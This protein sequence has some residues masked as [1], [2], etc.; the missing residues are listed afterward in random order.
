MANKRVLALRKQL[1]REQLHVQWLEQRLPHSRQLNSAR[2]RIA[3][4]CVV[5]CVVETAALPTHD[6]A[7]K[8]ERRQ[9]A[10]LSLTKVGFP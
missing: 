7:T 10:A 5:E 6:A 1:K 2:Q 8:K 3:Q 4:L 9:S